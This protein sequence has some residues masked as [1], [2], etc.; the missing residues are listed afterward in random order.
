M[1]KYYMSDDTPVH[2]A[3][4]RA[5]RNCKFIED[6]DSISFYRREWKTKE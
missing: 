5:Y 6:G 1:G 4:W 3:L 2:Q